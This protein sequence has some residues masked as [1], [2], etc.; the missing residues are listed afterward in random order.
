[1]YEIYYKII[2]IIIKIIFMELKWKYG[3]EIE[4]LIISDLK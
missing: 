4:K 2:H 3:K 1:M